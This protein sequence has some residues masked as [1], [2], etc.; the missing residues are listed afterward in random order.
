MRIL[1]IDSK[2]ASPR[3]ASHVRVAYFAQRLRERGHDVTIVG[4]NAGKLELEGA[5]TAKGGL[6]TRGKLDGLDVLLLKIPYAQE[7]SKAGRVMSYGGF[8]SAAS[9]TA[10]TLGRFDLVVASSS[11]LTIGLAGMTAARR[12][13]APWV[14]EIQDLWPALPIALG[15]LK[16]RR[17]IQAARWL[18]RK[19]YESAARVIVCSEGSGEAVR[20]LVPAEKVVLIPNIADVEHFHPDV[21]DPELRDRY[22]FDGKFVAIYAGQMGITNGLDQLVDAAVA[23]RDRGESRVVIAAAGQGPE[24]A[25]LEERARGLETIVFLPDVPRDDIPKV[26]GAAD[27]TI[28]AFAPNPMLETNSPNKFFDS[29]AAGKPTIVN[30]N[31][32]LRR[33]VE[34][35]RAGVYVPG[36][37]GLALAEALTDL[38]GKPELVA[39]MGKNARALAERE[40]ARELL[41]DRFADTLEAAAKRAS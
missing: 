12:S 40:F 33:L 17:E 31:G 8:T 35:N 16:G 32:W 28:T 4:R 3:A 1:Y 27:A 11:P 19:L 36:D 34:E 15:V 23:L 26:V 10:L 25:R 7:F 2:F 20:R 13:R 18:E 6:V 22:G 5:R 9:A 24:R 38:A 37:S 29:L 41:A 14:F 30:L 21:S 39:E